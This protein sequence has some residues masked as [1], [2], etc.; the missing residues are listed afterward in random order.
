MQRRKI[1]IGV[2][3]VFV[4]IGVGFGFDQTG[5][6]CIC[7][8]ATDCNN[9]I[10]SSS[11]SVIK[12]GADINGTITFN[13]VSNKILDGQGHRIIYS[14]KDND[15]I[16]SLAYGLIFTKGTINF[17]GI[18]KNIT[19]TKCN[20]IL[21][22]TSKFCAIIYKLKSVIRFNY[23]SDNAD[24]TILNC[25][26]KSYHWAYGIEF[27]LGSKNTN[28]TILNSVIDNGIFIETPYIK[29]LK[30]LNATLES[31]KY[32][33]V[34]ENLNNVKIANNSF[35]ELILIN[36]SNAVISNITLE[37]RLIFA[38]TNR[39]ITIN[40]INIGYKEYTTDNVSFPLN[41][42]IS[43]IHFSELSTNTNIKI[44]NSNF[45]HYLSSGIFFAFLTRNT[46]IT[47]SNC[48]FD[49]VLEGIDFSPYTRNT[50]ILISNCSINASVRGISF[51]SYS[52]NKKILIFNCSI[53]NT[54]LD[55]IFFEGQTNENIII[56]NC[57][58]YDSSAGIEFNEVTNLTL[59]NN[60]LIGCNKAALYFRYGLKN[61]TLY[62]NLINNSANYIYLGTTN[63]YNLILNNSEYGNYWGK[64]DGTGYSQ[65]CNDTNHD[66]ICDLPYD[67]INNQI[68]TLS[69]NL[70]EPTLRLNTLRLVTSYVDY[71][72][73]AIW[74]YVVKKITNNIS[75]DPNTNK[76]VATIYSDSSGTTEYNLEI[77]GS[78]FD[79]GNINLSNGENNINISIPLENI[80]LCGFQN[81]TLKIGNQT[82]TKEINF[83]PCEV[84]ASGGGAY[85]APEKMLYALIILIFGIITI[86]NNKNKT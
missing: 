6:E 73:L 46:N 65:I 29:N 67:P 35:G 13:G 57:N 50:N 22:C 23:N 52:T 7:Y 58:I 1:L 60:K 21:N 61:V 19:I 37:Q 38:K 17:Y 62:G 39:N 33:K 68:I 74:P 66:G 25:S 12:L 41:I 5:N 49:E 2:F 64:P 53:Y 55:G 78:T 3:L 86:I 79:N 15:I 36:I 72:P 31:G 56:S 84:F 44:I 8:N 24:I 16:L 10:N 83:G 11:C 45:Y 42:I 47:I 43:G 26:I 69:S 81:V 32:I 27:I 85:E 20:V 34:F 40:K 4:L 30:V 76:I 9:A 75:Y 63:V 48:N 80:N 77:E 71:K 59:V 18:N 14:L 54:Y 70:N 28:I 82:I 51:Y